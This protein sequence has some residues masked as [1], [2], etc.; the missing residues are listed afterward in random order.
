M[1]LRTATLLLLYG[2]A[3][4]DPDA[5][6]HAARVTEASAAYTKQTGHVI[7]FGHPAADGLARM[8]AHD[9]A[10]TCAEIERRMR[11]VLL[12]DRVP[13]RGRLDLDLEFPSIR[14]VL[15]SAFDLGA[16]VVAV[17]R[18]TN[19]SE[20]EAQDGGELPWI[21]GRLVG[22]AESAAEAEALGK[23]VDAHPP[24]RL[25]TIGMS[26]GSHSFYYT[27]QFKDGDWHAVNSLT[28]GAAGVWI[29]FADYAARE[30]VAAAHARFGTRLPVTVAAEPG[31]HE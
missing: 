3:G 13:L 1:H 31:H 9:P 20:R 18:S 23:A 22:G 15:V 5:L 10:I 4:P 12:L 6:L 30:G 7:D 26:D 14:P 28:P 2:C 21:D 29:N 8:A 25:V 27:A 19:P 24:P 17:G 11:P 16:V